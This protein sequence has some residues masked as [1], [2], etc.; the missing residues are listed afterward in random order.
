[1]AMRHLTDRS[2]HIRNKDT[3]LTFL[4]PNSSQNVTPFNL[5]TVMFNT[6]TQ[7]YSLLYK[8]NYFT[9]W[10]WDS[11]YVINIAM[12]SFNERKKEERRDKGGKETKKW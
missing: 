5:E 10:D 9:T 6:H 1:M 3:N 7:E 8:T 11:V 4:H 2:Q 12:T